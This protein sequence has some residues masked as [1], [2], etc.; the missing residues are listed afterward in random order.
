MSFRVASNG[1]FLTSIFVVLAF[2]LP[3]FFSSC[4][5]APRPANLTLSECPSRTYPCMPLSAFRA[6]SALR[7]PTKPNPMLRR[8]PGRFGSGFVCKRAK[9]KSGRWRNAWVKR[10]EEVANARFFTKSVLPF[11]ISTSTSSPASGSSIAT[12]AT[13][14][15]TSEVAEVGWN[16]PSGPFSSR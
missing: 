12:G 16:I 8:E 2:S 7:N 6:A 13:P 11:V 9:A 10:S 5:S 14:F 3:P 1:T 15:A 4:S